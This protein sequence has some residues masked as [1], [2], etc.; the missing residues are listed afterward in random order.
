MG[1]TSTTK[2]V[3]RAV[4]NTLR[5]VPQTCEEC[6]PLV[7]ERRGR[8]WFARKLRRT[9]GSPASVEFD[10][11]AILAR[12]EKRRDIVGFL[13]THPSF[14]AEPSQRDVATMQ[15][16]VS[17][18][19]KPLL[20]LIH[21]TDGLAGYLFD[22]DDSRGQRLSQVELFARNTIIAIAPES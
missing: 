16:W 2:P 11:P 20:C 1:R 18:F 9:V 10:G 13:H 4:G 7:G 12:E 17:A 15:A 19:G 8:L 6:W 14:P 3:K 5:G 22:S 21:G